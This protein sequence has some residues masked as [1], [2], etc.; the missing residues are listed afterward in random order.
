MAKTVPFELLRHAA[1]YH[2][3]QQYRGIERSALYQRDA[4]EGALQVNWGKD[5]GTA[6]PRGVYAA[7]T[8]GS[9]PAW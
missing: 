8:T 3:V 7:G 2:K 5:P 4:G 1:G 9:S 6:M